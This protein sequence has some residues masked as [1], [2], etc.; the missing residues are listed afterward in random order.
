[1]T[2]MKSNF[3]DKKFFDLIYQICIEHQMSMILD[4]VHQHYPSKNSQVNF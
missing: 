2:E 3:P 4:I 1:M